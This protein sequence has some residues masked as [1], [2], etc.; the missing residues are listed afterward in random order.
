MSRAVGSLTGR[1]AG[2]LVTEIVGKLEGNDSA[3]VGERTCSVDSFR[4]GMGISDS[5]PGS[6]GEISHMSKSNCSSG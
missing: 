2:A 5:G 3:T 4:M 1:G 6:C